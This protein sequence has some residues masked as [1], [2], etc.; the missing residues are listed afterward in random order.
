MLKFGFLNSR[1][2]PNCTFLFF[3]YWQFFK[4][5]SSLFYDEVPYCEQILIN[6]CSSHQ[7]S[8]KDYRPLKKTV[9]KDSSLD[10][11]Q[12]DET[13]RLLIKL[14]MNKLKIFSSSAG[15]ITSRGFE[16][17]NQDVDLAFRLFAGFKSHSTTNMICLLKSL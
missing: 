15:K 14:L 16:P 9:L 1:W 4:L 7:Q 13:D 17:L 5:T 11:L 12:P 10:K 6:L 2:L 8:H 3:T